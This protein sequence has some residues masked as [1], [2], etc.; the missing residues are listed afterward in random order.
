MGREER[1]LTVIV[2]GRRVPLRYRSS[3]E[4]SARWD[5]F[6][7]RDGDLVVSTRSKHGTTWTQTILL[8]LIH[9]APP[10][11]AS[12][13]ELSPWLDHLVEPLDVVTDRLAAQSH[14]RVIKTHTPL[15]GL[16][17]DPR[18]TYVVVAGIPWMPRSRSTTR[19]ATSI[20]A[21]SAI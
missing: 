18:A 3:E 1:R 13:G 6:D 9:G 7:H 15:D 5:G 11:P 12:L 17:L 19:A 4:D 2:E 21:G 16:P 14:R 10:W 20:V 8:L